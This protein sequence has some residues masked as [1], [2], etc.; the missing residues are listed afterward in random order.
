MVGYDDGGGRTDS[1]FLPFVVLTNL[2]T[3]TKKQKQNNKNVYLSFLG[4]SYDIRS[5][6]FFLI[7]KAYR[8]IVES[9]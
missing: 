4:E 7:W 2:T 6:N 3:Q 1:R 8:K 5:I 9:F